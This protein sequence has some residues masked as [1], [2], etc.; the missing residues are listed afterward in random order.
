MRFGGDVFEAAISA[1]V[2]KDVLG[3]FQAAGAAHHGHAF[4]QAGGTLAGLGRIGQV[5]IHV[6]GNQ[7]VKLAVAVVVHEGATRPPGFAVAGHPGLFA[8]LGEGAVI[9]VVEPVL[10]IVGDVDIIPAIV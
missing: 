4:P 10:A 2:V 8:N 7:Q 1:I 3:C 9:V 5:G 6:V